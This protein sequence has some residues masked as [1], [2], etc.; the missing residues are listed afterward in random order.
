MRKKVSPSGSRQRVR[1][2]RGGA[3]TGER[4]RGVGEK[5]GV[6]IDV[7]GERE[8]VGEENTGEEI[9]VSGESF[10]VVKTGAGVEAGGVVEDVEESRRVASATASGGQSG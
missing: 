1:R 4:V 9:E 7:E 10:G 2:E 8:A 5:E 3:S 6:V